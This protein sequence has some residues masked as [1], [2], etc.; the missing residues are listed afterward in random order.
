MNYLLH[1]RH[2]I[3]P[4][5]IAT[6]VVRMNRFRLWRNSYRSDH[7]LS[8]LV[9]RLFVTNLIVQVIA[10]VLSFILPDKYDMM[11]ISISATGLLLFFS[12]L[13]AGVFMS[14]HSR[15]TFTDLAK[16]TTTNVCFDKPTVYVKL[17]GH[18]GG[19]YVIPSGRVQK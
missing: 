8:R 17:K 7:F 5:L 2:L 9:G 13:A 4:W 14:F 1:N 6:V 12:A 15:M 10:S 11:L 19:Q 18:D 16:R 3:W